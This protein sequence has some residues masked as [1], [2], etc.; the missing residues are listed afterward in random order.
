MIQMCMSQEN[1]IY[2][3]RIHRE[4]FPVPRLELPFLIKPA[5]DENSAAVGVKEMAGTGNI[6]SGTKK[7]QF[8]RHIVP[9]SIDVACRA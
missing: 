4:R 1:S 3:P 7:L 6:L 8:H 5:I 9:H 2:T